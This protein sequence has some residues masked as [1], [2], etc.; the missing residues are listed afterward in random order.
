MHL[1]GLI[2]PLYGNFIFDLPGVFQ[3]SNPRVKPDL[4]ALRDFLISNST[5]TFIFITEPVHAYILLMRQGVLGT[6]H[7][8]HSLH[9]LHMHSRILTVNL[10]SFSGPGSVVG[11]ATGYKI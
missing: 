5:S 7:S 3:E 1:V 11:I 10:K 9:S 8:L 4:T 6:L 2:S